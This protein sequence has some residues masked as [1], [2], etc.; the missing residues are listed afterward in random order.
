L[1]LVC[2]RLLAAWFAGLCWLPVAGRSAETATNRYTF[3]SRHHPDGI[4]K[5]YMGRE[6]ARVMGHE[7]ANWLERPERE[8]Q[9]HPADLIE[10]LNLKPGQ[11]VADIG[12]GTGYFSRRLAPK[13]GEKGKVLAVDIQRE[14]ISL[15]SKRMAAAGISNVVPILGTAT[16]TRLPAASVDLALMVDV[17]HEFDFPYE[18]AESICRA[19]KPGGRVVLVEYRGEDPA[20]PIKLPHKMTELQVRREMSVLPLDWEQTMEVL[21]WQHIIIFRKRPG[22]VA[23]QR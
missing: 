2:A 7:S 11:V 4:G 6:I 9:E 1:R 8:R 3:S 13:V 16:N 15:L 22:W 14:M 10:L 5:F 20:V 23:G 17:Y 19:V 21:P 12:A 18:M